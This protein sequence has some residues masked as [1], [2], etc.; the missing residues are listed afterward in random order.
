MTVTR[1]VFP[2]LNY[3]SDS[4]EVEARQRNKKIK[5]PGLHPKS[6]KGTLTPKERLDSSSPGSHPCPPLLPSP[7]PPVKHPPS[8]SP[9]LLNQEVLWATVFPDILYLFQT[10]Q[11]PWSRSKLYHLSLQRALEPEILVS[12]Q[13]I[14]HQIIPSLAAPYPEHSLDTV[15]TLVSSGTW[16]QSPSPSPLLHALPPLALQS[17]TRPRAHNSAQGER[18]VRETARS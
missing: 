3:E 9:V 13:F 11:P 7:P 2:H 4:L 5:I 16:P 10:S 15:F 1:L 17:S 18:G 14:T 6:A 8:C 12:D